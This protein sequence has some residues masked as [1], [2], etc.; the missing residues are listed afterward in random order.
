MST[1]LKVLGP[2]IVKCASK[3][4]ERESC[5]ADTSAGVVLKSSTG[6]AACL[7]GKT[8]RYDDKGLWVSDG[9]SGEFVVGTA[10][11]VPPAPVRK[12]S[13]EYVP[14]AGFLL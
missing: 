9:C 13:P 8:W 10:P 1:L 11:E 14:N 12:K 4:A 2:A 3:P 6:Q 5:A 7:L